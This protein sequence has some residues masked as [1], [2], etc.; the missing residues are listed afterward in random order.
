MIYK[1][2]ILDSLGRPV[3]RCTSLDSLEAPMWRLEM[4]EE[5]VQ[6]IMAHKNI[7]LVG[8][9]ESCA[10]AEGRIVRSKDEMVW[11]EAVREL[12]VEVRENLRMPVRFQSFIYPISGAWKGRRPIISCDLSCGGLAFYCGQP[13]QDG[14]VAEVVIPVTAQPLVLRLKVLRRLPSDEPIPLYASQFMGLLR[15][16]ESMVREAVFSI[17]LRYPDN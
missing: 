7:T 10:A 6:R 12:N 5:D 1:Y 14:E 8:M 2:L 13:L 4:S 9:S 11:V 17:Q 15:E 3:V 16:E